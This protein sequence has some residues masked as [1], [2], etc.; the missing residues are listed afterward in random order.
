VLKSLKIF[1]L[2]L[3]SSIFFACGGSKN[4]IS[5][6]DAETANHQRIAVVPFQ[7]K[8]TLTKKQKEK[9]SDPDLKELNLAQGKE[10]QNAV[11]SYLMGQNLRVRIQSQSV[12]NSKLRGA[13]IDLIKITEVDVTKLANILGVDAVVVGRI[14][15]EQPMSDE[16]AR[17]LNVAKGLA[18]QAGGVLGSL[19]RGVSTTTNK[20]SCS[21]GLFEKVHGDRLWNFSDDL[22]MGEGSDTRDIVKKLM[23]SGAKNFPYKK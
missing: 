23:K 19:G 2:L 20:G 12:T 21:L 9:V 17:G 7:S 14:E 10:V 11:E 22:E 5:Q 18:R 3:L 13:N 1:W 16:L 8:I 4:S 15:T 6:F